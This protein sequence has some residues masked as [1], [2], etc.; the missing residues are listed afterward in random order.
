M[1]S[2]AEGNASEKTVLQGFADL[3][4]EQLLGNGR[5][6]VSI[7]SVECR[8][9]LAHSA[10]G[11]ALLNLAPDNPADVLD[12]LLRRLHAVGFAAAFPGRLPV[13]QGSLAVEDIWRLPIVLDAL[14]AA[15]PPIEIK[16]REWI[17][18]VRQALMLEPT[19]FLDD[20]GLES[21]VRIRGV[22]GELAGIECGPF[23]PIGAN[24]ATAYKGRT[25]P[26]IPFEPIGLDIFSPATALPGPETNDIPTGEA[27]LVRT[28]NLSPGLLQ[29]V[30]SMRLKPA[31]FLTETPAQFVGRAERISQPPAL[32]LYGRNVAIGLFMI[33]LGAGVGLLNQR[34]F[35][36]I[37]NEAASVAFAGE[38]ATQVRSTPSVLDGDFSS[39]A[40]PNTAIV[41]ARSDMFAPIPPLNQRPAEPAASVPA[42]EP[43]R[44]DLV[45]AT[46][47]VDPLY[48]GPS[49]STAP[50]GAGVAP[51]TLNPDN[52]PEPPLVLPRPN[53]EADVSPPAT[54]SDLPA[55]VSQAEART[56]TPS[57][58]VAAV[59]E[60]D[61][62]SDAQPPTTVLGTSTGRVEAQ[63]E[64]PLIV[65]FTT[66]KSNPELSTSPTATAIAAPSEPTRLAEALPLTS[67]VIS[68]PP[69]EPVVPDM[70]QPSIVVTAPAE[71]D[72]QAETPS[73]T[74][75]PDADPAPPLAASVAAA[76]Q[77]E[78]PHLRSSTPTSLSLESV[79]L[80][81][82]PLTAGPMFNEPDSQPAMSA[83]A[84][85][86][87]DPPEMLQHGDAAPALASATV[88][89][90]TEL[91]PQPTAPF[92]PSSGSPAPS[93][94]PQLTGPLVARG[95]EMLARGDVSGARLFYSR[96]AAARSA[97]A[98]TAMARTFDPAVLNALGVRGI[99][100]DAAQAAQWY[101]RAAELDGTP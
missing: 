59:L 96:A 86:A 72:R 23:S 93:L 9:A 95:N 16:G 63:P 36:H 18:K 21:A 39:R 97:A 20:A 15:Q 81:N 45:S 68:S 43:P 44:P 54:A 58:S 4:W 27:G 82:Q 35:L 70:E 14:F 76:P 6:A 94:E 11:I 64:I 33:G 17:D 12:D 62:A 24:S 69:T 2:F 46:L 74:T 50:P 10:F 22:P 3:G 56:L 1:Q 79:D 83:P 78:A 101:R 28:A 38:P 80:G 48:E 57:T 65:I 31:E 32:I 77:A 99:R 100:P 55:T 52:A 34:G 71:P 87:A 37:R 19:R 90:P 89:T 25:V 66:T 5:V 41:G 30:N 91:D 29:P 40:S 73:S 67:L 88:P 61:T 92:L 60:P 51:G 13:V 8:F 47:V 98:A 75:E 49:R 26:K 42:S 85:V 84:S 7:H 53:L